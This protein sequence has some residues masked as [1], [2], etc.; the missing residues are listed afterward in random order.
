MHQ[1]P[2]SLKI[3]KFHRVGCITE[4]FRILTGP[5]NLYTEMADFGLCEPPHHENSEFVGFFRRHKI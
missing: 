3:Q 4:A 1:V 5:V 2:P